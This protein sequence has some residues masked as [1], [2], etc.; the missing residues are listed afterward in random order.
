MPS[1]DLEPASCE[2]NILR[3]MN[4]DERQN[5]LASMSFSKQLKLPR[6]YKICTTLH[7]CKCLLSE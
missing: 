6:T 2:I 3:N 1:S 4:E 7:K 5:K